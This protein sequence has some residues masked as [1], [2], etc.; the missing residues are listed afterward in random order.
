METSCHQPFVS[1]PQKKPFVRPVIY[2]HAVNICAISSCLHVP[3][4]RKFRTKAN[5]V[6]ALSTCTAR[7]VKG[8]ANIG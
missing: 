4:N 3:L 5:F 1:F 6:Y 2:A 7:C 8:H